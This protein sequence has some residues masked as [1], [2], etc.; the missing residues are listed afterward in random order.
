MLESALCAGI[1]A[2]GGDALLAAVLPTPAAAVLVRRL[3]LDLA[4]V[5]S[6]SHNPYE[7]NGVKV[8]GSDGRK[9]PDEKEEMVEEKL[10]AKAGKRETEDGKRE[11][12]AVLPGVDPKEVEISVNDDTEVVSKKG[13]SKVDLE[14]LEKNVKRAQDAGKKGV[15]VKITH[16]KKVASKIEFQKKKGA[17]KKKDN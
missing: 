4:V 11:P 3:G 7:D 13:S 16:E 12:E 8:F 15:T 1:A 17:G 10:L 14:K 6:A 9:W 5:I 2:G